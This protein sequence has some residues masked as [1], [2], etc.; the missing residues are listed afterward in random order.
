MFK[1][2]NIIFKETVNM[3]VVELEEIA[4]AFGSVLSY[5]K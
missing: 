5:L 1:K 4:A 3:S 2:I